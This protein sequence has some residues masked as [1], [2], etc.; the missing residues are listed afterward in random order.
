MVDN[1]ISQGDYLKAIEIAS[2]YP[3]KNGHEY[4]YIICKSRLLSKYKIKVSELDTLEQFYK[5]NPH[6]KGAPK[7]V[8]FLE[9]EVKIKFQ[10]R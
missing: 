8:L 9:D 1:F 10:L 4:G 3:L 5:V 2:K 7:M 6:F